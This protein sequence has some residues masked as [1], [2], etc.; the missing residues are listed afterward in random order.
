MSLYEAMKKANELDRLEAFLIE[1]NQIEGEMWDKLPMAAAEFALHQVNM[2][3]NRICKIHEL[4]G[5]EMAKQNSIRLGMF[6]KVPVRVGSWVAPLPFEVPELIASFCADWRDMTAW[7]AHNRFEAIHPFEDGNGRVG[8]LLW[9]N[10][11]KSYGWKFERSFLHQYYYQT[12]R[13]YGSA[14]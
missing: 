3:P 10:K 8:R 13:E 7:E 6:R 12:L 9:L 11:M 1:S 4:L 2:T 14:K 5:E